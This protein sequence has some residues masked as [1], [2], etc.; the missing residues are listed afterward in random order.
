MRV[1]LISGWPWD[2]ARG[3]GTARFL[4]D[5]ERA[6]D[7]EGADVV[8]IDSGLDPAEYGAFVARRME[9]NRSFSGDPRLRG[10]DAVLALD[11]DGFALPPPPAGPVKI[12]CPQ[13][14][15][16][17]LA[18]TEPEPF[19][20]HLLLQADAERHNVRSAPALIVP[21]SYAADGVARAYGVPRERIRVI[22]HGFDHEGWMARLA[23][24]RAMGA[25]GEKEILPGRTVLSVAKLYPRK[26]IDI[27]VHAAALARVAMPDLRFRIVG[28]GIE[29]GRLERL[30]LDLDLAR[31]V[32]FEGDIDDRDRLAS[33]YASA[34]LFCLPSRHETFGFVFVEAMSAGLPVVALNAGAAPEV[35]GD[36]G[37]LVPPGDPG[38]LADALR[39]VLGDE[40]R[41][42]TLGQRGRRR[43]ALFS[44]PAA[45]ARYLEV[46]RSCLPDRP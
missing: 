41:A 39:D 10:L 22:P 34:D 38:A 37:I 20:S 13:A 40:E 9:W 43:A 36:A 14:V 19:R 5:I 18:E 29:R 11:Y 28:D 25:A 42:R 24:A 32:H 46:I 17:D 35:I 30:A 31:T 12:V 45:A 1:G 23:H 15:F 21:S 26:G 2:V 6:L 7:A 16:A 33:F 3:S 8:R 27:L 4:L 44:W